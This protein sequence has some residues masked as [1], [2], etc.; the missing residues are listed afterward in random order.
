MIFVKNMISV[1]KS[2]IR[3]EKKQQK[4]KFIKYIFGQQALIEIYVLI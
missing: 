2:K 1:Q 3:C 4:L